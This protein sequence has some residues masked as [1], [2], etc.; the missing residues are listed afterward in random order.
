MA[1][2]LRVWQHWIKPNVCHAL[3]DVL[4]QTLKDLSFHAHTHTYTTAPA[5]ADPETFMCDTECFT[6]QHQIIWKTKRMVQSCSGAVVRIADVA[7]CMCDKVH[8]NGILSSE[9]LRRGQ[10]SSS[11]QKAS[12]SSRSTPWKSLKQEGKKSIWLC[13]STD[14]YSDNLWCDQKEKTNHSLIVTRWTRVV[15]VTV[16]VDPAEYAQTQPTEVLLARGAGHLVAAI[17]FLETDRPCIQY[18]QIHYC[19]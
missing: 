17:D 3:E 2:H 12:S 7:V 14:G 15:K 10:S 9:A 19:T 11:L 1:P 18:V 6:P 8:S 4:S 16:W 13:V 5:L